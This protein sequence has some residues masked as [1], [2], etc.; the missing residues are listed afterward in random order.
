MATAGITIR[1]VSD[2]D[3]PLVAD[4]AAAAFRAHDASVIGR[5]QID[6]MLERMYSLPAL[7]RQR[8]E[9]HI[10][11]LGQLAGEPVAYATFAVSA[12]DQTE[13]QIHKLAILPEHRGRGIGQRLVEHIADR[14]VRMQRSRLVLTVNRGDILAINFAFKLG[15]TIRSAVDTGIGGGFSMNDF[16]MTK[17]LASIPGHDSGLLPAMR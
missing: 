6:Y 10:V 1:E 8:Q 2:R 12:E 14:L 11:L 5:E 15:F 13:G 17:R 7:R 4:L 9:G 3:L 16:I